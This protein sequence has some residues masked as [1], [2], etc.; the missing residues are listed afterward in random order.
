MEGWIFL[1]APHLPSTKVAFFSLELTPSLRPMFLDPQILP[2][3]LHDGDRAE[4]VK[5]THKKAQ[6]W[7]YFIC[8]SLNT[9]KC[10]FSFP[11]NTDPGFKFTWILDLVV[12]PLGVDSLLQS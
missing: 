11:F 4:D 5:E 8:A 7:T 12:K 1:L 3:K 2:W 10:C 6:N 9:V